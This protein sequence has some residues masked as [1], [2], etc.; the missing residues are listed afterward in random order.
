MALFAWGPLS[1]TSIE[2]SPPKFH[3]DFKKLRA[4]N[5][6]LLEKLIETYGTCA[7]LAKDSDLVVGSLRFYPKI[8]FPEGSMIGFCLQQEPPYGPSESTAAREFPSLKNIQDKTL[9]VHCMMAGSSQQ[10]KNPYKRKGIGTRMARELICWAQEHGWESIEATAY[11][12]VE[13][14]YANFGAAGRSFWEKLG[15]GLVKTE[16]EH[17]LRG[18]LLEKMQEQ[19]I[20]K[21]LAAEDARNKYTMRLD[22]T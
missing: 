19:V 11:E 14:M 22:L 16:I 13:I 10:K 18:E 17:E 12:E 15:F 9:K 4:V 6:P 8:L 2:K 1:K 3:T 20:A 7:I 5:I 21:G